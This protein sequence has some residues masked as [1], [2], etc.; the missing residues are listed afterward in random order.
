MV[1]VVCLL[2]ISVGVIQNQPIL[3]SSPDGT[4]V[5]EFTLDQGAPRYAIRL[6][7]RQVL[8]P[9]PLGLV[10]SDGDFESGMALVGVSEPESISDDYTMMH[11]KQSRVQYRANR[12]VVRLR[13]P[14]G[15]PLEV[16]L[17]VSNDGLAFRYR[18]PG[19]GGPLTVTREATGFALPAGTLSWLHPMHDAKTGW[20]RTNPSYEAHYH[21]E[22]PVG[23]PSPYAAGWAFPALFR[24][25]AGTWLLISETAVDETYCASRLAQDSTGGVYRIAF[26]QVEE[27]R[28]PV[29]PSEPTIRLPFESP[30]RLVI[31]GRDLAAIVRSNLATDVAPPPDDRD[32][33]FVRPGRAG[34]SWLR[35]DTPGMQLPI[36]RDYLAMTADLD[37][38]FML[39]DADWD[40]IVGYE[41]VAELAREARAKGVDL[42][43]WYNSAGDWNTTPFTPRDKMYLPEVRRAEFRRIREMG[44]V[45]VKVDF[46]G[47]D[48]QVT[49]RQYMDIL[50][51]AAD[52]QLMV[53]FHGATLQRG[54]QRTWPNLV[55]VEA[56]KGME[57]VTFDQRN[58]D[59]QAQHSTILPFSRNVVGSMDF[60]P[61]VMDRSIRGVRRATSPAF[62]L[63]LAVLFESAV[64]HFG[65]APHEA[66]ALP[67]F[68]KE[69][70]REVPAVWEETRYVA[71]FP[72]RDVV[73]ARRKGDAWYVVGINGEN[74]PKTLTLDLSFLPQGRPGRLIT[75]GAEPDSLQSRT[76]ERPSVASFEVELAP[77]GGFVLIVPAS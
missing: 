33:S 4:L 23:L 63:A 44:I 37:W 7:G 28:G 8:A 67:D 57:F 42:K 14:Q 32:W 20:E 73:L 11:G 22:Q 27:H 47:G 43:L 53:N 65:L 35:H 61:V 76:V 56:V 2:A 45:G 26:P 41:A 69:Y 46:F 50:R 72:G 66:A 12:R 77:Q 1:P 39:V 16:V 62:E 36:L 58:A 68:A 74:T 71:G 75:D 10:R 18:F 9:S 55:T 38:E 21:I 17:Q 5:V 52:H 48:K 15:Q 24:T 54:W 64:Q 29:D 19:E 3:V 40:R 25:E 34:W 70:L 31:V 30:W 49:M 6:D 13:N 60:T 51:D 59:Q